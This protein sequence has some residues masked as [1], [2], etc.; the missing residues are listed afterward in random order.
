MDTIVFTSSAASSRFVPYSNSSMT[1]A[2]PSR[3]LD[4][5]VSRFSRESR[6]SSI[7]SVT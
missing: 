2:L 5:I 4:V 7:I 1:D 3:D 6:A